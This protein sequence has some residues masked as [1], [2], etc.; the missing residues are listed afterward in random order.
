[1]AVTPFDL[2]ADVPGLKAFRERYRKRY[3]REPTNYAA[4][5]YDGAWLGV[6]AIR[7]AGLNWAKIRDALAAATDVR[8]I[9]GDLVFDDA[10][11][12]RRRV[13][14]ATMKGGKWVYGEPRAD[15]LF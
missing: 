15:V 2:E 3:G 13:T 12:N 11:A 1:M 5:G 10:L 8:G 6:R 14:L 4:H 9:T 7:E